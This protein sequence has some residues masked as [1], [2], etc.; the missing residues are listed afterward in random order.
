MDVNLSNLRTFL[1][2][3]RHRGITRALGE[4]H[5]TQ[6]AV[7]RQ[8]QGLEEHLDAQ[9]FVRKGRFLDLTEAGEILEQY[10]V[11]VFQL[12]TD[13]REAIDGLKGLI[14]GHLRIS[15][16]TTIGIYMIPDVLGEF[17]S[18]HPGIEVSLNV[19]NKEEV[20]RQ[21]KEGVADLGFV[22]PPVSSPELAMDEYLEDDMVLIV[23][24]QHRLATVE[25]VS[26]SALADEV[27]ILR[28]RGTGTREIIEEELRRAGV[29]LMHSMELWSTEAVKKTVAANLGV[30]FV[31]SRAVA[32]E[33]MVGNLCAIQVSNLNFRRT[34]YMLY[35][36]K[37]PLSPAAAGFRRFLMELRDERE[38]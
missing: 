10:A 17:K 35:L 21:V 20:I 38:A 33:V 18:E 19:S 14:R 15:A 32:L 26:T 13:A 1:T 16:A 36:R 7:T 28:E 4:L 29:D 6:P 31:S 12:L 22:M 8:I 5:L 37:R 34:T 30:A 23:S 27:F 25:T 2:V 11:R 3:A 9:L 24:P